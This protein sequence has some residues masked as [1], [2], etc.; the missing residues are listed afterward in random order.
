MLD[1]AMRFFRERRHEESK[2]LLET[3]LLKTKTPPERKSNDGGDG[4]G[5]AKPRVRSRCS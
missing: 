3:K 5:D 4:G 1:S 2:T